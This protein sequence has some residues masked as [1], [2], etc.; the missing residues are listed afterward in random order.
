MRLRHA[1]RS[2]VASVASS[3]YASQYAAIAA[4]RAAASIGAVVAPPGSDPA[5]L[6]AIEALRS[7]GEIVVVDLPG[8]QQPVAELNCC[9]ALVLRDGRWQVEAI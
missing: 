3:W 9:R 5:L 1:S 2:A 4:F 6:A 8:E 7:S